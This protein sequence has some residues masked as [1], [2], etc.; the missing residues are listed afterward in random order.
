MEELYSVHPLD[1]DKVVVVVHLKCK[2]LE[3]LVSYCEELLQTHESYRDLQCLK[4]FGCS[5]I[6]EI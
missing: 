4:R 6:T 5:G 1:L 2:I 3:V